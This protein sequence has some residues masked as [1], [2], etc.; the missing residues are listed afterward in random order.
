MIIIPLLPRQGTIGKLKMLM[1]RGIA[2]TKNHEEFSS[3]PG[4]IMVGAN[5]GLMTGILQK[6]TE[7]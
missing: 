5:I 3:D 4:G 7:K 1:Y 6:I 2:D